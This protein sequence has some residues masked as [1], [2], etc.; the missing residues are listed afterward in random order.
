MGEDANTAPIAVLGSGSWGTALAI[1]FAR[2][3]SPVRLWGRDPV[4][5]AALS[6]DRRNLHYLPEAEF[7]PL[8]TVATDLEQAIDGAAYVLVAVPS[9]AFRETLTALAP[10]LSAGR[11][12]AWATKGF[13]IDTGL[14]PHQV[15][16]QV[17]GENVGIAVLSGPTFANEVGRGLP[18]A[19]S[20][21]SPDPDFA[22]T[23]ARDL[24]SPN[25][26]AY[27]SSDYIGVEVGGAVKN[28]LAIGAGLCDGLNFGANT[29]IALITRGLNE[30][31][32]LGMALG[33]RQETFLG[34]AGFGDLVLT[35]TDNQSRNRR[36]G[37]L[38]AGGRSP[39]QAMQEIGQVV[40][41]Y[42][43]ARALHTV[44]ERLQVEMPICSGIY[45][46]LYEGGNAGDVVRGLM[47]RPIKAEFD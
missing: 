46:I 2:A 15:A 30:L 14:L 19:I 25:F 32:R 29:R 4:Q 11:R 43:A 33:A 7:P 36:F 28:V 44:A 41:G 5:R 26:R 47:S 38:L 17:L 35:C 12:V 6:R 40:E 20:V 45:R 9:H 39:E 1:Q 42:Q 22:A 16:Q 34:L 10:Y 13:E 31:M 37:L 27:I 23:I 18:T 8:L 3:G 24:S 21:A